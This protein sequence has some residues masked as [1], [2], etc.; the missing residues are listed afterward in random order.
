MSEDKKRKEE[1]RKEEVRLAKQ[2]IENE[3]LCDFVVNHLVQPFTYAGVAM[4]DKTNEE[5]GEL[6]K[7]EILANGVIQDRFIKLKNLASSPETGKKAE[8]AAKE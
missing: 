2:L 4:L 6:A 7:T 1:V 3:E 5:L 8:P